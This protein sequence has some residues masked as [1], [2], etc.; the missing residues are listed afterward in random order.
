M[1]WCM[2][3]GLLLMRRKILVI[4]DNQDCRN[5]L[6]LQ[7]KT[8]G[9]D[10]IE[11]ESGNAGV[12]KAFLEMPDLIIMDLKMRGIDGIEATRCLKSNPST[13]EI[14]IIVSTAW[15]AESSIREVLAA[16]AAVV[17]TKPLTHDLLREVLQ[18]F[19]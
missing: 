19:Q 9:Y 14:P 16:G 13:Q 15:I 5:I 12:E 3:S 6:V 10:V 18:K 8:L 7:L 4:E 11:A 2:L 17:L 1:A